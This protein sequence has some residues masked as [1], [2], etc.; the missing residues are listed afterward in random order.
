MANMSTKITSTFTWKH[1]KKMHVK[2]GL[3]HEKYVNI[4]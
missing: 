1:Y 3:N 4:Y 2:I